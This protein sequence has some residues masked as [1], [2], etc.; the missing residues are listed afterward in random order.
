MSW[1]SDLDYSSI[2][3]QAIGVD[4]P[5]TVLDNIANAPTVIGNIP[6]SIVD[7]GKGASSIGKKVVSQ[8][9]SPVPTISAVSQPINIAGSMTMM[10][11]FLIGG[12]LYLIKDILI[13]FASGRPKKAAPHTLFRNRYRSRSFSPSLI[14]NRRG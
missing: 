14:F 12:L 1:F 3:R 11:W 6:A 13:A 9:K 8:Q 4:F 5:M 7:Y 10:S 2:A